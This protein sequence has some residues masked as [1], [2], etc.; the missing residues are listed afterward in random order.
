MTQSLEQLQDALP[1]TYK[2]IRDLGQGSFASGYEVD[3]LAGGTRAVLKVL[4]PGIAKA[5]DPE[6]FIEA[7]RSAAALQHP[8]ILA[9]Y[10]AGQAGEYLYFVRPFAQG[11][12][13][14][15]R[16]DLEEQLPLE[17]S[18][19]I[20]REVADSMGFAHAHDV[21]H[22]DIRP[23]NILLRDGHAV[24]SDFGVEKAVRQAAEENLASLSTVVDTSSYMSPERL[25]GH[26]TLDVR[27][28]VY[29]LGCVLYEMLTGHPP[30]KAGPGEENLAALRSDVPADIVEALNRALSPQP[31]Q[32]F[33]TAGQ[34]C[35]ALRV[36]RLSTGKYAL[37][38]PT[39]R[40]SPKMA[41]TLILVVVIAIIA[42][43]MWL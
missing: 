31:D 39:S 3:D 15:D 11:E 18:L 34:F 23:E 41:G 2:V 20:A 25:E 27:S 16:L 22:G 6:R 14:R 4:R 1:S 36:A 35:D 26:R 29:S 12:S 28:D 8:N 19:Q 33:P 40:F 43:F 21:V 37:L 7:I 42:L 13:L 24:V 17:E 5:V 32:R 30:A 10:D 38:E 9:V